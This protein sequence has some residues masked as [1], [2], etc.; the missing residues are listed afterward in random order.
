LRLSRRRKVLLTQQ[1]SMIKV[2]ARMSSTEV[3]HKP[4][5]P[6]V[7]GSSPATSTGTGRKEM[8]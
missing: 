8:V 4:R 5:Q 1:K 3:K 6:K 7:E 2:W